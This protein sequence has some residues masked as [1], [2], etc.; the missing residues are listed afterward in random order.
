MS[1]QNSWTFSDKEKNG[2]PAR[3]ST[4]D[5]HLLKHIDTRSS[6]NTCKKICASLFDNA[7]NVTSL[8]VLRYLKIEIGLESLKRA[9][10]PWL[11]SALKFKSLAFAVKPET[12]TAEKL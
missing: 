12:W 11:N 1:F 10:K 4:R 8:I 3:T 9:H 6:T 2:H 7:T 5:D